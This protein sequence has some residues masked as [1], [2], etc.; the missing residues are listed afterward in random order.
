MRSHQ[1]VLLAFVCAA[2]LPAH[3]A[4]QSSATGSPAGTAKE[5]TRAAIG[6]APHEQ[7]TSA[8][9]V[10]PFKIHVPDAV[11][12]DLKR[13]LAQTRFADEI[14]GVGWEYGTNRAYLEQL[15][16]YWRDGFDWRAQERRLNQFDQFKTT[17]DGI[18]IHFIHQRSNVPTARPLLLLNGW[19]SSIDEYSKVVGPLTDPVA[20]GGGTEDAFHVVIPA[21]PGYG[22]SGKPRERGYDARR[23]ARM[24]VT[25]MARLGYTR[26]VVHG[27]D[28][29][30]SVGTHIA[31]QDAAHVSALHLINCPASTVPA[32]ATADE[33]DAYRAASSSHSAVNSTT[34]QAVAYGLSDSPVSQAAWIIDK[35]A[36]WSDHQGDLDQA[37]TKDEVLT[38]VMLYWVT[39]SGPTAAWVYYET[40]R[41][42]SPKGPRWPAAF[43]PKLSEGRVT[44][45]TGCGMFPSQYDRRGFG[46]V[47]IDVASGRRLAEARYHVMHYAVLPR[48]GHFPALEQPQLWLDDIRTFLRSQR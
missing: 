10:V 28:W 5:R 33:I 19:P 30:L 14:P 47:K 32:S 24:W 12:V 23:I 11:L 43:F 15:V 25:L 20:Y 37:Y 3:T 6:Q 46:P 48:G 35:W 22:F 26:Y 40:Q 27:S 36:K 41:T 44:V 39:N 34:P 7:P 18:D 13:R 2:L 8:A 21:M 9:A 31:L 1:A 42:G 4:A 16:A 29:G 38:N 17:I 45:P